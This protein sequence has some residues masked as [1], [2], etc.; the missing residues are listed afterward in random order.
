MG[1]VAEGWGASKG[2]VPWSGEEM[3]NAQYGCPGATYF[4]NDLFWPRSISGIFEG[5]EGGGEG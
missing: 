4:G 3:P 1:R 5:E 2:G